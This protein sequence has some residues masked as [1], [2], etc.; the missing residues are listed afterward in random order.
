MIEFSRSYKSSDG[1]C[2]ASL[3][4]AQIAELEILIPTWEPSSSVADGIVANKDAIL[5]ILT[6]KESSLPKARG[7]AK[8]RKPKTD[9]PDFGKAA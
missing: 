9:Q 6:L 2:H 1:K 5:G 4:Q 3:E 7:V 8:K